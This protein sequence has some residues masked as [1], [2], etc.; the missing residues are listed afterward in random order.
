MIRAA[1]VFSSSVSTTL[2]K[3]RQKSLRSVGSSPASPS[4]AARNARYS[5]YMVS[6]AS[7]LSGWPLSRHMVTALS[8]RLAT[9]Q[10]R[11]ARS[12]AS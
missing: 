7:W 12:M 5:A 9:T 10:A 8:K 11:V 1:S 6:M 2:S 3:Y 4:S